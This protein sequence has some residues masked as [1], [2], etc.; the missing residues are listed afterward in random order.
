M[1][2]RRLALCGRGWSNRSAI[3]L[4]APSNWHPYSLMTARDQREYSQSCWKCD[5]RLRCPVAFCPDCETIQPPKQLGSAFQLLGLPESYELSPELISCRFKA[6]A[7][8]IHPDQY[9]NKSEEERSISVQYSSELNNAY[10]TLKDPI[11][12]AKAL[13]AIRGVTIEDSEQVKDLEF[14]EEIID[15]REKI[16]T[17]DDAIVAKVRAVIVNELLENQKEFLSAMSVNDLEEAKQAVI[18]LIYRGRILNAICEQ[19]PVR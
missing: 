10:K 17:K 1:S 5:H 7:K 16:Q 6:V 12:R 14:L 13:L 8:R 18:K 4:P 9:E 3:R 11:L 2:L 15:L 19:E